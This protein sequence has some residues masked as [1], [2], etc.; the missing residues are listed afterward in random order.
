[1]KKEDIEK[2]KHGPKNYFWEQK[3]QQSN[4]WAW[5]S[6]YFLLFQKILISQG[7]LFII[8]I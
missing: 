1:M 3:T 7:C 5:Y 6:H 2:K 8:T 4:R